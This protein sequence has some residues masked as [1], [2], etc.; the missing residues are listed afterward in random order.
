MKA[1]LRVVLRIEASVK[2]VFGT[3]NPL[4]IYSFCKHFTLN[5]HVQLINLISIFFWKKGDM[6]QAYFTYTMAFYSIS[7]PILIQ[8]RSIPYLKASHIHTSLSVKVKI[9]PKA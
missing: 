2:D 9:V 5:T 6:D 4:I 7:N 3:Q 8:G 1:S